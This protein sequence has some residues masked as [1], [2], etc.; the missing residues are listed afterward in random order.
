M[1]FIIKNSLIAFAVIYRRRQIFWVLKKLVIKG[2]IYYKK[3]IIHT[4]TIIMVLKH[5]QKFLQQ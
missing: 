5:G 2:N 1:Y 4:Q 3:F